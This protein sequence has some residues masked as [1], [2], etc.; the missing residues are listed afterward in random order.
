M[1]AILPYKPHEADLLYDLACARSLAG[2]LDEAGEF[3]QRAIAAGF[4]QWEQ[5]EADPD[6]RALRE[7][8]R[9]AEI[10]KAA[11]AGTT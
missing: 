9:F 2:R 11:R 8:G 4:R 5:M 10:V 3:L 7:S 6:L 1:E